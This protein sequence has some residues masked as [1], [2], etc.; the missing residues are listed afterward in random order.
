MLSH[1]D[2]PRVEHLV[3][4]GAHTLRLIAHMVHAALEL[5][6]D[7]QPA[8]QQ[9]LHMAED[10]GERGAQLVRGGVQEVVALRERALGGG[11]G[12]ALRDQRAVQQRLRARLRLERTE[13]GAGAALEHH[14][15]HAALGGRGVL[16]VGLGG[17]HGRVVE[18]DLLEH[19]AHVLV[20][21]VGKGVDRV[22]A[23]EVQPGPFEQV[24]PQQFE[25]HRGA[26]TTGGDQH[27]DHLAVGVHAAA[28]SRGFGHEA[29]HDLLEARLVARLAHAQA[30][31]RRGRVEGDVASLGN[32]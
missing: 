30:L 3:N 12:R 5:L 25:A 1:L 20:A 10:A 26:G 18:A 29:A 17:R 9:Q 11:A 14:D 21:F 4:Q 27:S 31:E 2:H 13:G 15:L 6:A 19:R 28:A 24:V 7:R 32:E 23:A 8:P 16:V 22:G